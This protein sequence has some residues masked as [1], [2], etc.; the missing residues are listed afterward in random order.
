MV[1]W[2]LGEWG[3]CGPTCPGVGEALPT[4]TCKTKDDNSCIFPFSIEGYSFY[5]CL[6]MSEGYAKYL[7][8]FK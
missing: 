2:W 7:L 3:E 1:V 4:I 5:G 8:L 6:E